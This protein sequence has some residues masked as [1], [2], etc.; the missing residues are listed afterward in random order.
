MTPSQSIQSQAPGSSSLSR[1]AW[2]VKEL[3]IQGITARSLKVVMSGTGLSDTTR[4]LVFMVRDRRVLN[5]GTW[6]VSRLPGPLIWVV[7]ESL[8]DEMPCRPGGQQ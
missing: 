6:R 2:P 4:P 1:E 3:L 8:G 7:K 5:R